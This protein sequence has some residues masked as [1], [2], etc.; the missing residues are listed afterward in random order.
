MCTNLDCSVPP[1]TSAEATLSPKA[2]IKWMKTCGYPDPDSSNPGQVVCMLY[3]GT[4]QSVGNI[5]Y[6]PNWH[7]TAMTDREKTVCNN[8]H[9]KIEATK[10]AAHYWHYTLFYDATAQTWHWAGDQNTNITTVVTNQAGGG[11]ASDYTALLGNRTLVD[12]ESRR[13]NLEN[14]V[15]KKTQNKMLDKL[16]KLTKDHVITLRAGIWTVG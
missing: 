13:L 14:K 1:A 15:N 3:T 6:T 4:K 2:F 5:E 16:N 11:A 10:A 7:L 12:M 9:F 8:F